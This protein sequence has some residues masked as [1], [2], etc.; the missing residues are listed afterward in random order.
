MGPD[1]PGPEDVP[2]GTPSGP[3]ADA[4]T[5]VHLQGCLPGGTEA[6]LM[7]LCSI[8]NQCGMMGEQCTLL[9]HV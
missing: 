2:R 6:L 9:S 8:R 4:E 3:A 1:F 7:F 5:M